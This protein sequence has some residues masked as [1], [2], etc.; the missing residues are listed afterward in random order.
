MLLVLLKQWRTEKARIENVY[1]VGPW[2]LGRQNPAGQIRAAD[3]VNAVD[4]LLRSRLASCDELERNKQSKS[5]DKLQDCRHVSYVVG[6]LINPLSQK[7][8]CRNR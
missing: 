5:S 8:T 4:S 3:T 6:L 2:D 1:S 7:G